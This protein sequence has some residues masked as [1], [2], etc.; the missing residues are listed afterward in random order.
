MVQYFPIKITIPVQITLKKILIGRN[1]HLSELPAELF[2][3]HEPP[4]Q[5]LH[6]E[7]PEEDLQ[8]GFPG[9]GPTPELGEGE[10]DPEEGPSRPKRTRHTTPVTRRP[11]QG[12]M[13]CKCQKYC[14]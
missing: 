13:Y 2:H 5:S 12:T 3:S 4:G 8:D 7:G 11:I 14:A 9:V 1:N 6:L 10:E